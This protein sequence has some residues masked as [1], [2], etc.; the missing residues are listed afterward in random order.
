MLGVKESS[1]AMAWVTRLSEVGDPIL[2]E[3]EK[4]VAMMQEA[5]RIEGL[6]AEMRG[7]AYRAALALE[8]KILGLWPVEEVAAL[9]SARQG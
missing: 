8:S 9:K 2:K 6:A 4:I 1:G 7:Q 5:D 3:R